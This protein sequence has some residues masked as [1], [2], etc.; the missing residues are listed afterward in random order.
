[1][2]AVIEAGIGRPHHPAMQHARQANIVHIGPAAGCLGWNID[3]WP[4]GPDD[5]V[6]RNRLQRRFWIDDQLDIG[7]SDKIAEGQ[8]CILA[9]DRPDDPALNNEI[10]QRKLE[11][12]GRP[13]QQIVFC[14][15]RCTLQR[16][17]GNL[18]GLAGDGRALVGHG[19]CAAQHHRHAFKWNVEFFCDDLGKRCA[20]AGSQIHMTVERG[21]A[22][23]SMDGDVKLGIRRRR[24]DDS[25]HVRRGEIAR[26]R[27]IATD[28][29][30]CVSGTAERALADEAA[31]DRTTAL[32]TAARI[33]I[34][35]P[36]RQRL[37]R[38]A[39][40]ISAS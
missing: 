10:F 3:T 31:L 6:G 30:A 16:F 9:C 33:S 19:G 2:R 39:S 35:V 20:D 37:W 4:G 8:A 1:M 14:R 25:Q 26:F 13:A 38:S 34:W 15:R 36:Q 11:P 7:A 22:T 17:R 5:P 27:E 24:G 23:V 28:S 21:D 32:R 12:L 40:R 18:D 29:H